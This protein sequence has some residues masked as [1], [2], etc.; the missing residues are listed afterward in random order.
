MKETF[1]LS[2]PTFPNFRISC[3][4]VVG[5]TYNPRTLYTMESYNKRGHPCNVPL[6]NYLRDQGFFYYR[7]RGTS[8]ARIMSNYV[9]SFRVNH[10][11]GKLLHMLCLFVPTPCL[12]VQTVLDRGNHIFLFK[13]QDDSRRGATYIFKGVWK[14]VFASG[15]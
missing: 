2:L 8:K 13:L 4:S 14:H 3:M 9:E 15:P 6:V 1:L 11:I 12:C 5:L 7:L 10:F